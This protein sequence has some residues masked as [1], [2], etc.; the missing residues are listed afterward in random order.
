MRV[1]VLVN[2]KQ[3]ILCNRSIT[4]TLFM[5]KGVVCPKLNNLLTNNK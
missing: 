3:D 4:A 2:I 1:R 5:N